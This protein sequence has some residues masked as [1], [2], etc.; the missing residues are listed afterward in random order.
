ME[1]IGL[2]YNVS[3][4]GACVRVSGEDAFAY[5]QSQISQDLRPLAAD[6]VAYGLW[7]D[8]KGKIRADSFVL[9]GD[10]EFVLF[11][12]GLSADALIEQASVNVI[13]DDVMFEPVGAEP[14]VTVFGNGS[15]PALDT[16]LRALGADGGYGGHAAVVPA[17]GV[18]AVFPGLVPGCATAIL[19]GAAKDR[20]AQLLEQHGGHLDDGSAWRAARVAAGILGFPAEVTA[21]DLPQEVGLEKVAISYTKGCYFGQEVMARLKAMGKPRN[22]LARIDVEA[23]GD[24]PLPSDL[25]LDGQKVGD[26]R[27]LAGNSGLAVVSHR[28]MPEAT[29]EVTLAATGQRACLK[30]WVT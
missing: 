28:R 18:I 29:G 26:L 25:L 16:V 6:G 23:A 11:S 20:F 10:G 8:R 27:L 4:A 22:G 15:V 5:L 9:Q 12:Y 7:L 17:S 14:A 1:S 13:A 2:M 21:N 3:T 19:A 30:G 24:I